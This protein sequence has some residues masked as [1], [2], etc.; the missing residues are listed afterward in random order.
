MKRNILLILVFFINIPMFFAQNEDSQ[1]YNTFDNKVGNENVNLNYG[2]VFEEK[3]RKKK[4]NHNYFISERYQKGQLKFRNQVF[5]DKYIKY[6]LSE[7][8]LIL[9]V[10]TKSIEE[11]IILDKSLVSEFQIAG[12]KFINYNDY[13]FLE[14]VYFS[15]TFSLLKKYH[16]KRK[17]NKDGA[18]VYYTFKKEIKHLVDFDDKIFTVK[19]KKSF[20][21]EFPNQKKTISQFYKK[22]KFLHKNNYNK[23][24]VELM[25]L[26]TSKKANYE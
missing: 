23:F 13:G 1:L 4:G 3:Y 5:Y 14:Q 16:K 24:I 22:N 26:I 19:S 25:K 15:N 11:S 17:E 6:E 7:D 20:E 12:K 18:Y 9:K 2:V 8:L 10:N 21:R